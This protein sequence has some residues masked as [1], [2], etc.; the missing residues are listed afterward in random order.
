V[1]SEQRRLS[2]GKDD[3]QTPPE[4]WA[5]VDAEFHF[6]ADAACSTGHLGIPHL[7]PE[8][9]ALTVD[10]RDALGLG[11]ED[12]VWLNPPYSRAAGGLEAWHQA[13][14]GAAARGL[15]VVVLNPPRIECRWA[16][17]VARYADEWRIF[18]HRLAFVDPATGKRR[19][20]NTQGSMLTVYRP[21]PLGAG[22]PEIRY[23]ECRR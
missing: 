11:A 7:G 20:G 2:T 19:A 15:G 9:D 10:W 21:Y 17:Q 6:A 4:V 3:W 18:T 13:A 1:T 12:W 14:Y 16:S 8:R 22:M 5:M 23:I